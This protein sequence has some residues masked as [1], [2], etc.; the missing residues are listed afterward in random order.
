MKYL[1]AAAMLLLSGVCRGQ[2]SLHAG[3]RAAGSSG[4]TETFL[5]F[6]G[7]YSTCNSVTYALFQ[8][9]VGRSNFAY[10]QLFEEF[11]FWKVPLY[12]HAEYRTYNWNYNVVYLGLS[13]Q[14][15]TRHGMIAL[16]PLY[17][18]SSMDI[19]N[20]KYWQWKGS[21]FQFSV[22]TEHDWRIFNLNTFTDLWTA[23]DLGDARGWYS[24][25]WGYFP[26]TKSG[27]FQL[28][29]IAQL[30]LL[31][32]SSFAYALYPGVKFRF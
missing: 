15:G 32:G 30:G 20:G 2:I 19:Y 29:F 16:E 6:E 5:M 10:I 13:C 24:E 21:A 27:R 31:D 14:I 25:L 22:V 3:Q 18:N 8:D 17:R 9:T 26:I 1:A 28:G 7:C 11:R 12:I 4:S 23:T